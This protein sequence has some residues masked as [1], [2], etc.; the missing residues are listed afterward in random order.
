MFFS[1]KPKTWQPIIQVTP[2]ARPSAIKEALIFSSMKQP[3]PKT[4]NP[5][6]WNL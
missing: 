1:M 6:H 2:S 3:V 4:A 5:K